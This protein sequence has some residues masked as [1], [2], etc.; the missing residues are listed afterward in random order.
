MPL[1]SIGAFPEFDNVTACDALVPNRT[2]ANVTALGENSR[3]AAAPIPLRL[4]LC[5][6]PGALS[7]TVKLPLRAPASV[8]L[9]TTLMEQLVPAVIVLPQ[10]LVCEKSPEV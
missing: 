9:N 3:F 2:F 10:L 1:T 8:G 7:L 4:M 5:G 6:L